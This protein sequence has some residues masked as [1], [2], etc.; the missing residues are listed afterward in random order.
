M[1]AESTIKRF[2]KLAANERRFCQILA[3]ADESLQPG[4]LSKLVK[5]VE[6]SRRSTKPM[7]VAEAKKVTAS[8][9]KK[10]VLSKQPYNSVAISPSFQSVAV[11]TA[12]HEGTFD[13][14][15]QNIQAKFPRQERLYSYE[16]DGRVSRDMRIAFY[17]GDATAY[18][19]L[20]EDVDEKDSP[21]CLLEPFDPIIYDRL[22]PILRELYLADKR[23]V[24]GISF[25]RGK[26][27]GPRNG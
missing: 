22:A 1:A 5:S 3:V 12:I 11:Q 4:D 27:G 19:A 15:C 18:Q 17:N 2:T 16:S 9:V 14:L 8:L 24:F 26:P 13:Q 23:T 25:P 10:Q 6:W 20:A 7:T 21:S